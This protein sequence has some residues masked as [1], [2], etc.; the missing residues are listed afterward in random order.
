MKQMLTV[1]EAVA[2]LAADG[3]CVSQYALRLWLKQGKVPFVLAGNSKQLVY[4]PNLLSF[5]TG[6]S[7]KEAA[8]GVLRGSVGRWDNDAV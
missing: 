6:A 8:P 5:L 4:Y 1:R 7:G 2:R 3:F